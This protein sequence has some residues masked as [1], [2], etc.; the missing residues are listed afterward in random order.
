MRFK[1]ML[2]ALATCAMLSAPLP[3]ATWAAGGGDMLQQVESAKTP[4]DHAALAAQYDGM[5]AAA[6]ANAATHRKMG[7]AYKG[8]PATTGGKVTAASS[9]PQH[10]EAIAKSFD[11]QAEMY[12]TMAATE[13]ELGTAR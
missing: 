4:A 7:E 3:A 13:R 5:A 11:D 6:K 9:M 8:M 2:M 1:T 10:C 12:R